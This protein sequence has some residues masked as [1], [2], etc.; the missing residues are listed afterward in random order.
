MVWNISSSVTFQM[1]HSN[2]NWDLYIGVLS[3]YLTKNRIHCHWYN[4]NWCKNKEHFIKLSWTISHYWFCWSACCSIDMTPIYS[5]VCRSTDSEAM[6][7]VKFWRSKRN[8]RRQ[9][10]H[11]YGERHT[12]TK[13]SAGMAF[14]VMVLSQA[15]DSLWANMEFGGRSNFSVE[16]N[17]FCWI[18]LQIIED[19]QN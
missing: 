1:Q 4:G 6:N 2:S 16:K 11:L 3:N 14:S 18:K 19:N 5:G 12:T 17:I 10:V 9:S 13:I 8:M 7:I 15:A